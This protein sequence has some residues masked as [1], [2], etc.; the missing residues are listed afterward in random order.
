M[1]KLLLVIYVFSYC[2]FAQ[3]VSM[4]NGTFN[5]C[6]GVF[7][8]SGGQSGLYSND[9]NFTITFCPTTAGD[10]VQLDFTVFST[11]ANVDVLSIYN[12][13]DAT[14]D[15]IGDF[16]GGPTSS[17]GTIQAQLELTPGGIQNPDGCLTVVFVS[18]A[19]GNTVGWNADI[20]CFTPCQL[21]TA[22]LDST[23]PALS[24]PNTVE[25]D[26]GDTIT[27]NGS[28][29]FST[30]GTG[31]T[32]L[33]DFGDGNTATGQTVMHT[34]ATVGIYDVNLTIT[35]ANSCNSTNRIILQAIV[36]SS[37]VGNPNVDAGNDVDICAGECTDLQAD[38]LDIGDTSTYRFEQIPFVPPFAFNGLSNSVNTN[39]DDSWAQVENLPFDFCFFTNT[40][41][42]FQVGSNGVIR[43]DVD[44]ADTGNGYAL[45]A[46]DNLPNNTN[47]T[48][49]EANIFSPV[50]D[51]DPSVN[52]TNEIR[53]EI[54]GTAPNRV[55]AVAYFEVPMFSCTTLEATH[56]AVLYETTNVVDIYVK[57]KSACTAFNGGRAA[58][59]IQNDAGNTA[60][61]PPGRNVDDTPWST[62]DE[63]WRFTPDGPDAYTF[64]WLDSSGTVV[65]NSP[66]FNV[67]PSV[68]STYTARVTYNNCNGDVV[69]VTDD[70]TVNVGGANANDITLQQCST[71]VNLDAQIPSVLDA[72]VDASTVTVSFHNS[73]ADAD[74]PQNEITNTTNYIATPGEII[75]VAVNQT[76]TA[77]SD[78]ST[79]TIQI[80]PPTIGP[81]NNLEQCDAFPNDG[82]AVFDLESQD[83]SLLGGLSAA[84]YN[85]TYYLSLANATAGTSSLVSPYTNTVNPQP[86]FVRIEDVNDTACFSVSPIAVFDLV[87]NPADDPSFTYTATCD[88]GT[89]VVSGTPGGVFAFNPDLGDGAVL[90]TTTGEITSG[91]PNETYTVEYTTLGTC[92]SATTETVTVLN[93]NNTSF[94]LTATCDGATANI[95]GDNGGTF[96]FNPVPTDTAIIDALT[97]TITNGIQGVTYNVDYSILGSCPSITNVGITVLPLE[98]ASFITTQTCDGATVVIT[99]DIGGTFAFNPLPT[100]T[101]VID[102]VTGTITSG[103]P[104]TTYTI[105]YTTSG[106]CPIASTE[107]VLVF[108]AED[109]SFTYTATCDG[110]TVVINGT[111]GG[112]FAFNP[113]LGDGA[114]LDTTTGEITSGVS[115][116]TYTVEY[117]TSGTCP[118]LT[119]ET[120]TVLPQDDSSFT[121]T[122][123]CD[124]AI[125]NIT[126]LT[127]GVFAFNPDLGDGATIDIVTGLI[128][129]GQFGTTY[130]VDYTTNGSCPTTTNLSI[131]TYVQPTPTLPTSLEV[132]DDLIPDGFTIIDLNVKNT[133]ITGGNTDYAVTYYLTLMDAENEINP[134][135]I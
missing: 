28:G 43:F 97:G 23:S 80:M 69:V 49:G 120:V 50:H 46:G 44:A 36:G 110:G 79:I 29:T 83:V 75:Y 25:S 117:T 27:F 74:V 51:I 134:L 70:V 35:D 128:E 62:T 98:D 30:S 61:V 124:G 85:V 76:G 115:N 34:Y 125:A 114:V 1:K 87:V 68:T 22:V 12:G 101:A 96:S 90:D 59:G 121:L 106:L 94:N 63:A 133:E 19:A 14:F 66:T 127:G 64:E 47:P 123:T 73:Q 48:L 95:I 71:S 91:V 17:P 92:P 18:D 126:G 20:S 11:Q 113:D 39:I 6:M 10:N 4:Q 15:L 2:A 129:N 41:T 119:T 89:V 116:E 132:C 93:S 135:P 67:C 81:A 78:T 77:C 33:W 38:F 100:D 26:L 111:P 131:T 5:Q 16:S 8:D 3:D 102:P 13:P 52:N 118:T 122:P 112:V 31:A 7:S 57:E 32:Y 9:E 56:M 104:N 24:D 99:G 42:Q 55:L 45:N 103:T 109:S 88:G 58:L 54:I 40:E 65:S 72:G 86:I 108:P 82:F 130:N 84:N 60:F 107:D 37:T 21:I 53:W 105:E